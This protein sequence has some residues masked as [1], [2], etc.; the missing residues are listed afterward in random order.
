M[1]S[2]QTKSS[3]QKQAEPRRRTTYS[4]L[5]GIILLTLPCYLIGFGLLFI[6]QPA[7]NEQPTPTRPAST[8]TA[9]LAPS[10]TLGAVLPTDVNIPT[11]TVAPLPTRTPV[12]T[13]TP[14]STPTIVTPTFTFTFTPTPSPTVASSPTPTTPPQT[15]ATQTP[16]PATPTTQSPTLIPPTATRAP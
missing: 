6:T 13:N 16:A 12:P 1:Q 9:L 11:R 8:A 4:V 5:I 15:E 3:G 14:S 10:A 2:N 7:G